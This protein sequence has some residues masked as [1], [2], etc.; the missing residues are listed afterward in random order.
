[1]AAAATEVLLPPACSRPLVTLFFPFFLHFRLRMSD[2]VKIRKES[3]RMSARIK[4]RGVLEYFPP[5]PRP[6]RLSVTPS[7]LLRRP[8]FAPPPLRPATSFGTP[9][10]ATCG[11]R[12]SRQDLAAQGDKM[13]HYAA[14]KI[15][16][17]SP[18]K[19]VLPQW[20][21]VC[22]VA[23]HHPV[24]GVGVDGNVDGGEPLT[25]PHTPRI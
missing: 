10:P 13:G 25:P 24:Y 11:K 19:L 18:D 12:P 7:G 4:S 21:I 9:T 3:T 15:L 16:Q 1:M 5:I 6:L 14:R 17:S 8:P 20:C 2:H 23:S 22:T